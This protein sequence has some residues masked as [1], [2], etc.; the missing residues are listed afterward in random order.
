MTDARDTSRVLTL[1]FTDLADSTALK[2]ARG[3]RVV[4]LDVHSPDARRVHPYEIAGTHWLP[5]SDVVQHAD[6]LP[7]DAAIVAYCT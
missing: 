4:P 5:L 7:R 3:D 1:V 6:A 2:T